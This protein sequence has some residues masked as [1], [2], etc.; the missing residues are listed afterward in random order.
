MIKISKNLYV[1]SLLGVVKTIKNNTT[2]E[3]H[4]SILSILD[5]PTNFKN[6]ST[7]KYI[8]MNDDGTNA[9]KKFIADT[10]INEAID[11]IEQNL[12]AAKIVFVHCKSGRNR[13]IFVICAY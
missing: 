3:K 4:L 11:Y 8:F 10:I 12:M 1:G 7:Q 9:D 6:I 13:S 2:L 5:E